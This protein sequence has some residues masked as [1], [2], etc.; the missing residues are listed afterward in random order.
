MRIGV[1]KEI[2]DQEFRVGLSPSTVQSLVEAQ[3]EVLIETQAGVGSGFK[4]SDYEAVGATIVSEAAAAW[5]AQLVIKVKE[6][7]P[8]EYPFLSQPEILFTYLH[9]AA[10]RELTVALLNSGITA[11]AYETVELP[12]RRLPLLEPMSVIAGRLAVH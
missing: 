2:K 11:I 6:P 7:L 12:N 9:L 4:D 8:A 10:D 3:H 5:S 1:P